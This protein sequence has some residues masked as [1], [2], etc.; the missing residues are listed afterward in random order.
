MSSPEERVR[1]AVREHMEPFTAMSDGLPD[2]VIMMMEVA[3]AA[4]CALLA[5]LR[6]PE[7]GA[8]DGKAAAFDR[9][10]AETWVK[11]SY[12]GRTIMEHAFAAGWDAALRAARGGR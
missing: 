10:A 6:A 3:V 12:S 2:E 8:A 9:W 11:D 5:E 1:A 7:I 4:N